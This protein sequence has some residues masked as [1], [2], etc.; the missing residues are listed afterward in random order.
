[1]TK[2]LLRLVLAITVIALVGASP[3]FALVEQPATDNFDVPQDS[4]T[5]APEQT[6]TQEPPQREPDNPAE[7]LFEE[8][9][10]RESLPQPQEGEGN[11][12]NSQTENSVVEKSATEPLSAQEEVE[13]D[14]A[15]GAS[16]TWSLDLDSGVLELLG[17]GDM[18]NY[19][20]GASPWAEY[21][22][23]IQTVIL[24]EQLTSIG[25]NAFYGCT[26][27]DEITLPGGVVSI[28]TR[29]FSGCD[30]LTEI[31][32]PQGN[33]AIEA[34]T[35]YNCGSLASVTLP[36][37]IDL[38]KTRAFSGCGSLAEIE[39]PVGVNSIGDYAFYN[40]G[41]LTEV[42][43]P[44]GVSVIGNG[45]FY[46][47]RSLT[48]VVLSEG[49]TAIGSTAFRSCTSL[50]NITI[51]QGVTSIGNYAFQ[52]CTSLAE[53]ALPRE[54]NQIAANAF[55]SC[56][57]LTL[58]VHE[59]SYAHTYALTHRIP[60]RIIYEFELTQL[61]VTVPQ[62]T[63]YFPGETLDLT[64]LVVTAH[65]SN[66]ESAEVSSYTTEPG[67]GAVLSSE[68]DRVTVRYGQAEQ[69]FAITVE[70]AKN[71]EC[72]AN[73][74]WQLD[75]SD[76]ILEISGS[77]PMTNY[78]RGAAPW[79]THAADIKKVVLS[80]GVTSVGKFAFTE[81]RNLTEV[82]LPDGLTA[83]ESAAFD[84]CVSLA[85]INL[86]RGLRYIEWDAFH[87]CI[88]LTSIEIPEGVTYLG[89]RAFYKCNNLTAV[90]LPGTL[91]AIGDAA[92]YGCGK[93]SEAVIP[94]KV[95]HI[96]P[97][98]F[99]NCNALTLLVSENSY[100]HTFAQEKNLPF[101]LIS[102]SGLVRI[103]L[104]A[105]RKTAYLLGE[106][107]DLTG[108]VVT[109]H[110]ESG[111]RLVVDNYTTSPANGTALTSEVSQVAVSYGDFQESFDI[112]VSATVEGE[113]G[114]NL[115][116]TLNLESGA[117]E[118]SGTGKMDNYSR[119]S[120]PWAAYASDIQTVVILP[121]A[122]SVGK[123]A[124]AECRSLTEVVIPQ[125]VTTLE[126]SAFDCCV[127]LIRVEL[128]EG[129]TC[130]EWDTFNYCVSLTEIVVPEGVAYLGSR[131]FTNCK[132]LTTVSLPDTLNAIGLSAFSSCDSLNNLVVPETVT[133]IYSSAFYGCEELVLTVR[134][135]SYGHSFA[136]NNH[137]PFLLQ[138]E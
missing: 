51:P 105:P 27:L 56:G 68:T 130:I 124:F 134:E 126:N 119:K 92:F 129:L 61:E 48:N 32:I 64:G 29:A 71:G 128:P 15:C 62:K 116:W 5:P 10:L 55:S 123:F 135:G 133:Y 12:E 85:N 6:E 136:E 23:H 103:S 1:M 113:C 127:S 58:A 137:I 40:C 63:V 50:S 59:S 138:Q 26:S 25:S 97:D 43:L 111:A 122:T 77:G 125:G 52:A 47:C 82:V 106:P 24:P 16:L 84:C 39:I 34:Y 13:L 109:A 88:G 38:I 96:G 69:S 99:Q 86:P 9:T 131:A 67:H 18:D 75:L 78:V 95:T 19:S 73:L 72:G 60:F 11:L 70:G 115:F 8:E 30:S 102:E 101:L 98:A 7:I 93:L 120:A 33:T 89:S 83:I 121:G 104:S 41:S 54:I 20:I 45:A 36:D 42:I 28:G 76:G 80:E 87:Y 112:T 79:L 37:G 132:S 49:L 65:Y 117:L 81:C 21:A 90:K 31:E 57:L 66:G 2:F 14:R 4:H 46:E 110:Y 108:L 100:A 17:S 118:I 114:K 107:L 74:T 3:A 53:V 44:E 94:E 22:Q 35:F 91:S